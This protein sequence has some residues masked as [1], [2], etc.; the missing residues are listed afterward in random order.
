MSF[1]YFAVVK[2]DS[3][4]LAEDVVKALDDAWLVVRP[5]AFDYFH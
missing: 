1:S 3:V 4:G 5:Y 2:I